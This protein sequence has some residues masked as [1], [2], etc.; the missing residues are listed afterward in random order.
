MLKRKVGYR[1]YSFECFVGVVVFFVVVG[2]IRVGWIVVVV[3]ESIEIG[4]RIRFRRIVLI[5]EFICVE[6][7][8]G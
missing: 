8:G 7:I 4:I 2:S 3:V 6:D 5:E 1:Y